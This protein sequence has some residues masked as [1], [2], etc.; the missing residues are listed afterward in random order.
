MANRHLILNLP[1]VHSP[2][3]HERRDPLLNC[4]VNSLKVDDDIIALE[5]QI[6][7]DRRYACCRILHKDAFVAGHVQ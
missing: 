4:T 6:L 3:L 1:N 7:Q 5:G 2:R